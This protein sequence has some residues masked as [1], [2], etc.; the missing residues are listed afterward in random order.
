MVVEVG[1]DVIRG[2]LFENL[3]LQGGLFVVAVSTVATTPV[4]NLNA[5]TQVLAAGHAVVVCMVT[6]EREC[7]HNAGVS[8]IVQDALYCKKSH[9]KANIGKFLK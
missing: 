1:R 4:Q 6:I 2:Q 7:I 3:L 8:G 5:I 9:N